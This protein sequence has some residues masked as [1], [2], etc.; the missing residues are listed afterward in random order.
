MQY[1]STIILSSSKKDVFEKSITKAFKPMLDI[2][3]AL[4]KGIQ[5]FVIVF[6]V[7]V[8][9]IQLLKCFQGFQ[10]G[11]NLQKYFMNVFGVIFCATLLL[12]AQSWLTPILKKVAGL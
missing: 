12:T 2:L 7:V 4:L 11:E 1:L 8:V 3:T 10:R 5:P 6:T 9:A